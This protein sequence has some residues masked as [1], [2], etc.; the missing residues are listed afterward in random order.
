MSA[1]A[2]FEFAL[3]QMVA[4]SYLDDVWA[5]PS[6]LRDNR[7]RF[8]SNNPAFFSSTVPDPALVPNLPGK[9]RLTDSQIAYFNQNYDII[10]HRSNDDPR[11]A[12]QA[13]NGSGFSA[14]LTRNRTTG[15]YTLSFRSL[16][17][18]NPNQGG[19]WAR[20]GGPGAAGSIANWGFAFAQIAA[21]EEYYQ[22]L[23]APGGPLEN[24]AQIN[25]T[26]YSLGGH[27]GSVFTQ[28]HGAEVNHAYLFN[29]AGHGT[30]DA[31]VGTLNDM[32]AYFRAV[33]A[34]PNAYP[35]QVPPRGLPG[36]TEYDAA[37][38]AQGAPWA[39]NLYDT[40]SFPNDQPDPR[41]AW[42]LLVTQQHF[43][44]A[45]PPLSSVSPGTINT[46]LD[47]KIT[48]LHG[49]A[50]H[51]DSEWV[52]NSGIH[53]TSTKL[54]I[55]DQPDIQG[56]GF[57]FLQQITS[58]KSDYGT[59]HSITLVADTLAVMSLLEKIGLPMQ[60]NTD[61]ER[62]YNLFGSVSTQS[63]TSGIFSAKAEGNSLEEV[64]EALYKIFRNQD[65]AL[66]YDRT[67]GGF[68]HFTNRDK[69]YEA[70]DAIHATV[71]ANPSGYQI[72]NL[73]GQSA[74]AIE[75]LAVN[76]TG[77][78]GLAYRYALAELNP[79][80]VLGANYELHNNLGQL[81]R[82]V[83]STRTGTLT[84]EWLRDRSAFLTSQ[85]NAGTN[86]NEAF[87]QAWV[88]IDGAPQHF[89]DR[90]SGERLFLT[91]DPSV[92]ERA[93]NNGSTAD[94]TNIVFGGDK[95]DD[96][97]GG[98]R[99]DKLYGGAGNDVLEGGHDNDYL[100][101]GYGADV[102]QFQPG[103]GND[104]IVDQDGKGLI[105]YGTGDEAQALVLGIRQPS[106]P[107]GQYRSPDG[108]TTYQWSGTNGDPLTITT[109]DGT[110]TVRNF[111]K[112]TNDLNLRL[113]DISADAPGS[114]VNGNGGNNT[115]AWANAA[116]NIWSNYGFG[117]FILHGG[118]SDNRR[119]TDA[120]NNILNDP[121]IGTL[122]ITGAGAVYGG[123]GHD[124]L[125]SYGHPGV[126]LD[127]GD[128]H[129]ILLIRDNA[130]AGPGS[131]LYGGSGNDV[132]YGAAGDDVIEG[133]TGND[134]AHGEEGK[135][136]MKGGDG[137]DWFA[138]QL[139]ADAI[140]GDA[141]ND[142]VFGG[143][144]SDYL[145]GGSGNDALYGD[146]DMAAVILNRPAGVAE[147]LGGFPGANYSTIF[148]VPVDMAG[149]DFLDG[150][151][152]NDTLFGGAGDDILS[153]GADQDE[154]EGEGG[155]DSL[156]GGEGSDILWGD[157][158]PLTVDRD[159]DIYVS[160]P[161]GGNYYWRRRDA[162]VEGNDYLS[163]GSGIDYLFGQGGNDT[164]NG[165]ADNDQLQGGSGNDILDGGDGIDLLL[166]EAGNDTLRGG[167]GDDTLLG[168][169]GSDV[170]DGGAGVDTII[171]DGSDRVI[172]DGADQVHLVHNGIP[173]NL[174]QGFTLEFTNA[175]ANQLQVD[176]AQGTDGHQW[177]RV[178]IDV[179]NMAYL[180]DGFIDNG[181]RVEVG[182][183]VLTQQTVM[184]YASAAVNVTGTTA[185]ERI[186][187][188][189]Y[190]DT[191]SG[192]LGADTLDGQRG[193]DAMSGGAGDDI[194]IVDDAGDALTENTS[195]GTDSAVSAISYTLGANV[196]N[197]TLAGIGN[198]QGTGNN[199]NNTLSGNVANNTLAG[200]A[201]DDTYL[202]GTG[203]GR[204]TVIDNTGNDTVRLGA[205]VTTSNIT[206]YRVA[207]NL[208][209][210]LATSDRLIVSGW[211]AGNPIDQFSFE[212]GDVLTAAQMEARLVAAPANT[213]PV[214]ANL[215]ADQAAAED[216]VFTF[217]V[218]A[219]TFAE[220]DAGDSISYSA[221]RADG[222]ALPS[223][224][225]FDTAT[226]TF[227]G[228][229][230]NGDVGPIDVRVT[231][232]D[233]GGL[234]VADTFTLSVANTNDIPTLANALSDQS[235]TEGSAFTYQVPA[236]AFADIDVGDT[237]TYSASLAT[238]AALPSWLTFDPATRT[239]SGTP[240]ST[241][242]GSY[243]VRV[244]ATDSA[245][246]TAN[247]VFA[248]S[249]A[250]V[251]NLM[252]GTDG[253]DVIT[254]TTDPDTIDGLSGNDQ[255]Q[256]GAGNDT[257][258][259]RDGFD[260]LNGESGDDR[261]FG[262]D[263]TDRLIG[264]TGNDAMEGGRGSDTYRIL[265]G[266]GQDTI[267]ENESVAGDVDIIEM[268]YSVN[269]DSVS[270]TRNSN[271]LVI[272]LNGTIDTLNVKDF[273]LGPN[274]EI[275]LLDF[276]QNGFDWD[277]ATLK[278]RANGI[279]GTANADTLTGDAGDNGLFGLA[280]D[281]IL[282]GSDGADLLDGGLGDD[283]LDAG[284]GNDRLIGAGGNNTFRGGAGDDRYEIRP[285]DLSGTWVSRI[286]DTQGVDRMDVAS[287]TLQSTTR[288]GNDLLVSLSFT[289][290]QMRL[291]GHYVPGGEIDYIGFS[292]TNI[293]G[294]ASQAG[295]INNPGFYQT[296]SG[297]QFIEGFKWGSRPG[298]Q[299]SFSREVLVSGT[300]GDDTLRGVGTSSQ[301]I[302]ADDTY[303]Y[304]HGGND[305]LT[306]NIWRDHLRGGAGNDRMLGSRG[307]DTYYINPSEQD[308]VFDDGSGELSSADTFI[309]ETPETLSQLT[310]SREG[311]DLLINSVRV[312]RYF[313]KRTGTTGVL[314]PY[315]IEVLQ[316][317]GWSVNLPGH[318]TTLGFY[319]QFGTAG[320]DVIEGDETVNRIFGLDGNDGLY[321]FEGDDT[322]SGGNGDDRLDGDVGADTM[323]GGAGN[324]IYIVDNTGDVV[325]E[326]ANDGIDTVESSISYTLGSNVEGLVL[327]G[328]DAINGTG[329]SLDNTFSGNSDNNIF[330][331]GTGNDTYHFG[332]ETG[333]DTI[334]ESDSTAG[335]IDTI[336]MAEDV[337]P[338]D[339][340]VSRNGNNL[341]LSLSS[342]VDVLTV[343]G[344]FSGV[345]S[346]IEQVR[347]SD[348]TIWDTTALKNMAGS[349]LGT[350]NAETLTGTSGDDQ[351]FGLGGNDTLNGNAGNDL[352]DGGTGSDAMNGGTGND[353]Y[354]VDNTLDTV[355][356]S[357]ST[358]GTDT[359]Q[360]SVDWT[361][362]TNVEHLTLTGTAIAGSGNTLANTLTG[363]AANN[364]LSGSSGNDTLRG[365][366]GN[367]A[368]NGDTGADT[369]V[370]GVGDDTYTVDNTGDVVTEIANEGIDT[371][372]SSITRTLAAEVENL[373][374]TGTSAINGTGNSLDNV[375]TGNSGN[376]TLNGGTGSDTLRGGTGNDTY[377]VDV[378]TDVVTE[379]TNEGTDTVQTGITYT[380]G[381]NVEN[382]TLTGSAIINGTG[383]SANNV[384]TGNSAAN[385]LTGGAGNDTLDGGAGS[386][387]MLGG[388]GNDTYVVASAGDITTENAGEGTD[389]VRS[390]V[391][392]TL[393]TNLE[394]LVLTG[395]S[396]I[397]GTGNTANNVLT[398][399]AANN[400]LTGNDGADTLDGAA[401]TDTL[402]GG[403]GNDT[404]LF[405]RGYG[406]DTISENDTT[407]GNSDTIQMAA[408]ITTSDVAVSRSTNNLILTI[409]TDSLTVT[410][411]YSAT[412]NEI[413]R[414]TFADGT[415]WTAAQL[416]SMTGGAG[417]RLSAATA[418]SAE[419]TP[420]TGIGIGVVRVVNGVHIGIG[421]KTGSPV[422]ESSKYD[423]ALR[424]GGTALFWPQ[425][426]DLSS[427]PT[428]DQVFAGGTSTFDESLSVETASQWA[429]PLK[430]GMKGG[431]S[432]GLRQA[433]TSDPV[434][435]NVDQ[436]IQAMAQF[437]ADR[438]LAQAQGFEPQ[439]QEAP[440]LAAAG[441]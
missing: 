57:T 230:A 379:N 406:T 223:W 348:G 120:N 173:G 96:I 110:I 243:D 274:H 2:W 369:M 354:I 268:A 301:V 94:I 123:G 52:A 289:P 298:L 89:E 104:I 95:S 296:G 393:G 276:F 61:L 251:P 37:V 273:F 102:Y 335:N 304:G 203:S 45:M 31:S 184:T 129:D 340:T 244:T 117:E 10:D 7:L 345:A 126:R 125:W 420:A 329:N 39:T 250:D 16:E 34:N 5:T 233:T 293:S 151:A 389:T 20:D 343:T 190:N 261:L 321:G 326:N 311:N 30:F 166:G 432:M 124:D 401:G 24:I 9:T 224:L 108:T 59:T 111:N 181:Q 280:G 145:S 213:A 227:T 170:L 423:S 101:G 226:Q 346:E 291:A 405:N 439:A 373:T 380:L 133:G 371:L 359:V 295:A 398:G 362:R 100:E 118:Y 376:N 174:S 19:D 366:E 200:L 323:N 413:E 167:S 132:I 91:N 138:G 76:T 65:L 320:D 88:D 71:G 219:S 163:G 202:F 141:N 378:S 225:T 26:G 73:V 18:A 165:G 319:D 424:V 135:D 305:T 308:V 370:G 382:L 391:T 97:K 50:T 62:A 325:T 64:V 28:M 416:K 171:I 222:T 194:Y 86:N 121:N 425:E 27:L 367:D 42:A 324:D 119:N 364:T 168:G 109:S 339:V 433:A 215:I 154:L 155:N 178:A 347:F 63:G 422:P 245:G 255:I 78:N 122:G 156:F 134:W 32:V 352:L 38:N 415:V 60:T 58:L 411:F 79:F 137:I 368:L 210:A 172:I 357:S 207:D 336:E 283:V 263:G 397:N 74:S 322:L 374:L 344:F 264:L 218:P 22:S 429:R 209:V 99:W 248:L 286:E 384:L 383:N 407:A 40:S 164:L 153:G 161:E 193:A 278:Y 33:L 131:S 421:T 328:G 83:A 272:G 93:V 8:G 44:T 113:F 265:A 12:G 312:E 176:A 84:D 15:E 241:A 146:S 142:Y 90:A 98:D 258:Y 360:S 351:M 87:G 238:G 228:T 327:T 430:T 438:G 35:D 306:G 234:S 239:F 334:Q 330:A 192:G 204:D 408:G 395:T 66:E 208:V 387:T 80:V 13:S 54:F 127:G 419:A 143:A 191:L 48:Q 152:D 297:S 427:I 390:S 249:V 277:A 338:A 36:W 232:T 70:L 158:N 281:D 17:Y 189:N 431:I 412:A 1:K 212:N 130:P 237:L 205:G 377:V 257:L 136:Y 271:D 4:E 198:I 256:S 246:A 282:S 177:M 437:G 196:E 211:F 220:L 182:G 69:F 275:E 394:N 314:Y 404:Y 140:L 428:E 388:L 285:V 287:M 199:L 440:V 23:R 68:G 77:P 435:A 292:S 72:I 183:Q 392:R 288:E 128:G 236:N 355:T 81:E 6:E 112:D 206:A 25:V 414:V 307:A 105:F 342:G 441:W 46:A 409:G 82:Y 229:P 317:N 179:N 266:T 254:G 49:R 381:A 149:G 231:A 410:N 402:N 180:Q 14:T 269:P 115:G 3:V 365:L 403:T 260:I 356:E 160:S 350:N 309:L 399:N 162:G 267:Y 75:N 331:G 185:D 337:L 375:I 358:G 341:V 302:Q 436:L 353:T 242:A 361:L 270:V 333:A 144:G 147:V 51:N 169:E 318:L 53:A 400:T 279:Y 253:N 197:L 216:A 349:I 221:A 217:Q 214:V 92:I 240:S 187:G 21:M 85:I 372:L 426:N 417:M 106:D 294:L 315:Q 188:S 11:F 201:G 332:F 175:A 385:T 41:Y 396:A 259:G 139:G 386:D 303:F 195:D 157:A 114:V 116:N 67:G 418:D 55:E 186:Y 262:G 316:G 313:E 299:S 150:G 235:G 43:S 159:D 247:D 29:A 107:A 300:A 434:Q 103:D 252:L 290:G 148:D 47:G 56:L 363:N 284:A 310:F